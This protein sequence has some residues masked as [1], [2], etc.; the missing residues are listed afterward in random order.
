MVPLGLG[1][2]LMV[3]DHPVFIVMLNVLVMA[4]VHIATALCKVDMILNPLLT[5]SS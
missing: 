3:E 2:H 4:Q 1:Q 5:N